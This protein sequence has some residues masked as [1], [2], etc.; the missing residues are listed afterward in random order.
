MGTAPEGA[1]PIFGMNRTPRMT[2]GASLQLVACGLRL[3]SIP[4]GVV[5]M[6]EMQERLWLAA[7]TRDSAGLRHRAKVPPATL[8]QA[9]SES[10]T[11]SIT[12]MLSALLL[13][14]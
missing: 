7:Y 1:V 12:A 13:A 14:Q 8:T 9:H 4:G 10:V 5:R 6:T 2:V 3:S 11:Q